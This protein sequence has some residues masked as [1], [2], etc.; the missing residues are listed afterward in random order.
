MQVVLQ[1]QG[2]PLTL[3][4]ERGLPQ[5]RSALAT[6]FSYCHFLLPVYF[7]QVRFPLVLHTREILKYTYLGSGQLASGLPFPQGVTLKEK[8]HFLLSSKTY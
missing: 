3:S 4:V 5:K 8:T 2:L 1:L 7:Y 6:H